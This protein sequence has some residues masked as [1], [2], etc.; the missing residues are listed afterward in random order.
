M[1]NKVTTPYP[2]FSDID[3]TPLDAGFLYFG[4]AGKDAEQFPISIYWDEAKT[5][6]A[7]QPL[8]T[9]NGLIV[10]NGIFT[11]IYTD[12]SSCSVV[13][14]NR[15]KDVV[16]KGNNFV[17]FASYPVVQALVLS[18]KNRAISA[19]GTLQT[20]IDAEKNRALAAEQ[21]LEVRITTSV[22]SIKYFETEAQL[23]AFTP[24][25]TDPQQAYAFDTKKN[26][27]W[28]AATSSWK[29]E[30][31]SVLALA[32]DDATRKVNVLASV[33]SG[34]KAFQLPDS[35]IAIA[36]N[37]VG[38]AVGIDLENTV[39]NY[40]D[41][42]LTNLK[43]S[44]VL[45]FKVYERTVDGSGVLPGSSTDELLYSF[46]DTVHNLVDYN[47]ID[48]TLIKTNI[49]FKFPELVFSEKKRILF[50]VTSTDIFSI[51]TKTI[52]PPDPTL[53]NSLGGFYKNQS[54]GWGLAQLGDRRIAY[55]CG[56]ND[57][58]LTE[59]EVVDYKE[60]NL[61]E[62]FSSGIQFYHATTINW[63]CFGKGFSTFAN[64]KFN[65]ISMWFANLSDVAKLRYQ[66]I[67]R[68]TSIASEIT[69]IGASIYDRE[70][71]KSYVD[72]ASKYEANENEHLIDFDFD[73]TLVPA[74][75][76]VMILVIAEKADGSISTLGSAA[77][78][79]NSSMT[80]V[81]R[82]VWLIDNRDPQYLST[83]VTY[84]FILYYVDK[85]GVNTVLNE[86][87]QDIKDL[88]SSITIDQTAETP[89]FQP[90]LKST[91]NNLNVNL[92]GTVIIQANIRTTISASF[93]H[94]PSTVGSTIVSST[95]NKTNAKNWISNPNPWLGY[96][97][98]SNV[99]VTNT[100]N[101][102]VLT[103]GVHYEV[104]VY[105]GKLIGLTTT[106]YNVS[107]SFTYAKERYDI[108]QINPF[109]LNVTMVKGTERVFDPGEWMVEATPPNRALCRVLV[110]GTKAEV[111]PLDKYISCGGKP[112]ISGND[113]NALKLHNQSC[114]K[115]VQAKLDKSQNINLIGYGDSI[116]AMGGFHTE[117]IPNDNHDYYGFFA[118]FPQDLQDRIPT[119]PYDNGVGGRIKVGWN[120]TLK[121]YLERIHANTVNYYNFA[122]SGT[123]S[124]DGARDS[125]LQYPLSYHPDLVVVGFGMNDAG[126]SVLYS[127][128]VKI[129]N[130][131]KNAG[132]DVV[133]MPV[134]RTPTLPYGIYQGEDWRKI[135][136]YVYA[137]ALDSGAA[138]CPI[139]WYVD[140]AH[141]GGIGLNFKH[142]CSQNLFNHPGPYEYSIYGKMLTS[143]F[144]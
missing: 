56:Y 128:L 137:A 43:S 69:W 40:I 94:E 90:I 118:T 133:L 51:A 91:V 127:N 96:R 16:T 58:H 81:D 32:G 57:R 130:T 116:T 82:G 99:V 64:Q 42:L 61:Y 120:W 68:P 73:E 52:T 65:K 22:N 1:S 79:D 8:R 136:R 125:R 10:N 87:K 4:E 21:N 98:I 106:A 38:Y 85:R 47:L 141:Y 129:V 60:T 31:K 5:Q 41:L 114:L 122:V 105:G 142:L 71:Y 23:L 83:D 102:T 70:I 132:S 36:S 67:A 6:L 63:T 110:T 18:E 113:Y 27:L 92:D 49:R 135:N 72:V 123:D 86:M 74:N 126:S 66:I 35:Q 80:R 34:V 78:S 76:F 77:R 14:K 95:L 104:D 11:N 17:Q 59:N 109:T 84:P 55:I 24:S 13:V 111:V 139:D 124:T 54:S 19:E 101:S 115:R 28:I 12:Q 3:G 134:V 7:T 15:S 37:G 26:Y 88:E 46:S 62:S 131:F 30:G 45:N 39:V 9:R 33:E 107:V 121:A 93:T 20:N 144:E 53:T 138:Y 143:V 103:E 29:D 44:T 117:D 48:S 25:E 108:I 119:Y 89:I 50:E 140:D 97:N 75:H 112:Y 100:A 2:L